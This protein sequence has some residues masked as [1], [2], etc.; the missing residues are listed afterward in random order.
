[1]AKASNE[2]VAQVAALLDNE[3]NAEST[4]DDTARKGMS[5]DE[6]V[7]ACTNEIGSAIGGTESANTES[8]ISEPL[9][10]YFG[11][12]PALKGSKAK[13][14]NASQFVSQ[15]VMDGIEATVSEIMPTFTTDEIAFYEPENE[16]DEDTARAETQLVNYLFFE[17]YDGYILLQTALKDA[18]L[19]RNCTAKAYWDERAYVEFDTYEDVPEMALAQVLQPNAEDQEV[20]V[21]HQEITKEAD[22]EQADMIALAAEVDPDAAHAAMQAPDAA[23]EVQQA[24]MAAQAEYTIKVKRTTKIGKPVVMSVPPENA[25]VA[26]DHNTPFLHNCR[27][28][29]HE[30]ME[31]K[32]S[33]IEQGYD[34][35]IVDNL[36]SD[37]TSLQSLSR[38]RNTK[39]LDNSTSHESTKL[40]RVYECYIL[41]DFDG[42]GIAERRKVV[43]AGN[44]LLSNEEWSSVSMVG[45]VALIVPHKYQ[46]VS[47]FDR[48]KGIQDSKTPV[49][50]AI[51]DGTQLSS[52][53]RVGAI[54]GE[55][56]LDDL[57]T[58]RTGGVV[59]MSSVNSVVDLPNPEVPQSSY[60]MLAYMDNSRSERGGSAIGTA[61]QAQQISGDTAHGIERVMSAME[62]NNALIGRTLGETFVRGIFI[63]LHNI[64]RENHTGELSAKIGGRWVTTVP[65]EWKKRT[66]VTVQVGSSHAER[67]R[68]SGVI[69]EVIGVQKELAVTGSV[70]YNEEKMYTAITDAVNLG[71]VKNPE[72]YFDDPKSEEAKQKKQQ[73]DQ[74]KQEMQQKEDMMNQ[75]MT[76]AQTDIANAELMKGRA[77]LIAQNVKL[78][79]QNKQLQQAGVIQMLKTQMENLKQES[80]DF[81]DG[82]EM[83]F[84][85]DE[86]AANIGLALT[87]L[88]A[89]TGA[90]QS[91]N[92]Q[93]N[94]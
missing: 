1:M 63:E 44:T 21:V 59:R 81:K 7:S 66:K 45:G 85:Y 40:I 46:G 15:D 42:D 10:Y 12:L 23:Q 93:G 34:K 69:K 89:T 71:G 24:M 8:D 67:A 57:L 28:S 65:K 36:S 35:D 62:L 83:K 11:R 55:V 26:G 84:K 41:I 60:S 5:D 29:S 75:A 22:T 31:T 54:T 39:D 27:F 61:S 13:D 94:I 86:L 56:N 77:E 16:R 43:I 2:E 4:S 90:D 47:L 33:L 9:D 38:S 88:E 37:V 64:I 52:N 48:L 14:P 92:Y 87:Q 68:Q 82:A 73:S 32:S 78:Q 19:H 30:M 6:L 25:V 79:L 49:V 70:M 74:Q 76:K 17:E 80:Q 3:S 58:S 53:P 91:N 72:R 18:L 20:E 51:V 50:R